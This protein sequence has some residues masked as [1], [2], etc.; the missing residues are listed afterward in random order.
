[1]ST[2]SD[3]KLYK[4]YEPAYANWRQKRSA[5]EAKHLEYLQQNPDAINQ[6]DIKRGKSLLRAI[7]IMDEYSQKYAQNMEMAN[8]IATE[9]IMTLIMVCGIA[10]GYALGKLPSIKR[11]LNKFIKAG[12]NEAL[13]NSIFTTAIGG[14]LGAIAALPI[15]SKTA[16]AEIEASRK[17]RFEAMQKDL[18]NPNVF[19]VLNDEQTAQAEELSKKIQLKEDT[20]SIFSKLSGKMKTTKNVLWNSENYKKQR[21]NFENMLKN[22]AENAKKPISAKEAEKAKKDQQLLTKLVDKIDIASQDYA[23]NAELSANILTSATLA[24]GFLVSLIVNQITKLFKLKSAKKINAITNIIAV[25]TASTAGIIG[26]SV[27]KEASRVGRYKAKKELLNNPANFVYVDDSIIETRKDTNVNSDDKLS[28]FKFL[29]IVYK[30]TKEYNKYKKTQAK[31]DE[32]FYKAVEKL[33]LSPEQIKDAKRLQENTF[34]T[35]NKIDQKSQKFSE[36]IEAL[37]LTA[38]QP[39]SLISSLLGIAFGLP[40]L[41]KPAKTKL[42]QA[43]NFSKYLGI[44]LVSTLPVMLL[45]YYVTKEQKK[46]SRVADMMAINEM[47]DYKLFTNTKM[48]KD[49]V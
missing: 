27:A 48:V 4:Q 17:G 23:E 16:K 33:E 12:K 21:A 36:N 39:I 25:I 7:D 44:I 6:N 47:Q 20:Q 38:E 41:A 3:Y 31:N 46:A 26:S 43:A 42:E 40:V 30:D 28:W 37:G 10:L 34:M 9:T 35:F 13:V 15:F 1:M 22:K 19:A 24:G 5:I 32:K 11:F 8:S 14:T 49:V 45:N 2:I 29:K 18:I